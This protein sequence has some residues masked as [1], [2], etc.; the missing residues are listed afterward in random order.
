M[1]LADTNVVSVFMTDQD[2]LDR[3]L[4]DM[5]TG[6]IFTTAITRAEVRAGI[7]R[8]PM[9][10]R[11]SDLNERADAYFA[12]V[13]DRTLAFD[14]AA[15]DRFGVV[16]AERRRMGRPIS[17]ADAQIAAIALVHGAT[18]ATRN[19]RDFEG[20]GLKLVDPFTWKAPS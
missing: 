7:E 19:V 10:A 20:V 14:S 16:A 4:D 9:G 5:D 15:A 11:R 8:L 3:W 12:V 2:Q 18:V 1:F 13:S 17:T 6:Q